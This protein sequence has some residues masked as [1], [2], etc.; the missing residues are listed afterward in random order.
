MPLKIHFKKHF[1]AVNLCILK[2]PFF[3]RRF[4]QV[5]L[6][7]VHIHVYFRGNGLFKVR[8]HVMIFVLLLV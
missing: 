6:I 7:S 8:K 1:C 2:T 4:T 3:L 5:V